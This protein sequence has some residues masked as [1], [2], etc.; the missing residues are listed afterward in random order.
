[1]I[2]TENSRNTQTAAVANSYGRPSL[3]FTSANGIRLTDADGKSWFDALCGIGVTNLGHCNPQ[4]ND[5]V[6]KQMHTLDHISNLYASEPQNRAAE[7]LCTAANME[8]VFFCNSGTEANEAA[9]KLARLHGVTKRGRA[10]RI[11][12]F[13]GAFHGRSLGALSA[14]AKEAIRTPFYPLLANIEHLP[15][16]DINAVRSALASPD[17]YD[18]VLLEP[19][20]GEAGVISPPN[21][22]LPELAE[23]CKAHNL[24]FMVDEVQS[25]NG[26]TGKYFAFQHSGVQPDVVTT[27][28]GLANGFPAGAAL[29]GGKATG[30]FTPGTH[31]STYGGNP[32]A[33]AAIEAVYNILNKPGFLEGVA[34]LSHFFQTQLVEHLGTR[35]ERI[36]GKGLM[37]GLQLS[38]AID[39]LAQRMLNQGIL[40][41][42]INASRIRLLPPLIMTHEE[43]KELAA[44]MAQALD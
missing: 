19:I 26:R 20:Q 35:L 7:L 23:L 43:A 36:D 30:L 25:G 28:K 5:A 32:I 21:T 33:C 3:K 31:G 9:I 15:F 40:V 17:N 1:M 12:C 24:L 38:E 14:T 34:E 42:V 8:E 10:G 13:S 44:A 4:V 2:T 18:A 22:F 16:G 29:L 11:I 41:N 27:A 37:L 39:D 6:H